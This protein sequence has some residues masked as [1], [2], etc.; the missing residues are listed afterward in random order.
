MRAGETILEFLGQISL[1][2]YV[3]D[4]LLSSAVERQFEL[5]GEAL[6]RAVRA[7]PNLAA[8]IPEITRA[9]SFRNVLAHGYDVVDGETVFNNARSHLP[10]LIESLRVLL[11]PEEAR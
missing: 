9:V 8:A 11:E 4:A 10:A 3:S 1:D 7:E 5:V 2:E 6:A